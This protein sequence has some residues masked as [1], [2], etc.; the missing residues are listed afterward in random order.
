MGQTIQPK[1][2]YAYEDIIKIDG[3]N[4]YELIDGVIYMMSPPS[5]PHQDISGELYFQFKRFLRGKQCKVY[6][7]PFSV[8][9]N[10][11]NS[12][13]PDITVVC[14]KTKLLKRVVWEHLI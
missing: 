4:R 6:A 2:Q 12:Y 10:E 11:K 3:G 5:S 13:E 9:L 1:K 7:A 14:D 8:K